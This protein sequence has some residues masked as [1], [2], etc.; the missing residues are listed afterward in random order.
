LQAHDAATAA[1]SY[2]PRVPRKRVQRLARDL[3][4]FVRS[5][6]PQ[7]EEVH[8]TGSSAR[9]FADVQWAAFKPTGAS[10]VELPVTFS[11][12]RRAAGWKLAENDFLEYRLKLQRRQEDTG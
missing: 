5:S 3:S 11:L 1:R 2:A 12:V 8:V 6:Q 9:I 7:I 10:V 4:P